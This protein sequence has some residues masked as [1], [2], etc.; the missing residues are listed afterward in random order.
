M[1]GPGHYQVNF[2]PIGAT[3]ALPRPDYVTDRLKYTD[4]KSEGYYRKL[5][6]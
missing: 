3:D 6:P 2:N 5:A 4:E 1:N